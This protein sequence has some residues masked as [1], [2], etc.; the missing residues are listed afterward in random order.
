MA[1]KE[2]SNDL[3]IQQ[4][5]SVERVSLNLSQSV[6]VTTEDKLRLRLHAYIS[7]TEKTKEWIAPCSLLISLLLAL[8][9]ADFKDFLLPSATWK[10]IF[11][12]S[13]ILS[14]LWLLLSLRKAFNSRSIDTLI[15]EIK[16]DIG[17]GD[18]S[19]VGRRK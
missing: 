1:E 3:L 11:I 9:S 4:L 15:E 10:A 7:L 17:S 12:I 6:I 14:L 5:V 8:I 13:A 19:Q 2:N 16:S 18:I